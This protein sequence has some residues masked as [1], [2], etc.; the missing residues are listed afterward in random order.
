MPDK[1]SGIFERRHISVWP[2]TWKKP[3]RHYLSE[4]TFCNFVTVSDGNDPCSS[5]YA[6]EKRFG[7]LP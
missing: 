3:K 7:A 5:E 1:Y 6:G 2:K 4:V